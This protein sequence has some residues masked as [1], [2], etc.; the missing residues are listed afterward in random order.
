MGGQCSVAQRPPWYAS[1][2]L[3]PGVKWCKLKMGNFAYV[4]A[5]PWIAIS[6]LLIRSL[7][8]T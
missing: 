2:F 1:F 5:V 8:E 7:L 3:D 4:H 6:M